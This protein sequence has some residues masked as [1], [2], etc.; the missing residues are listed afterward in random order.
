MTK[1]TRK[2][3]K[4]QRHRRIRAKI[5]GT[6]ERPRL[7]V[8]HSNAHL[9][10]QLIDDEKGKTIAA[11]SDLKLKAKGK[12]ADLA[13]KLGK[14]IA[15]KAKEYKVT[16]VVFDRGGAKYHGNLKAFAEEVRAQGIAL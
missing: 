12:G 9:Y 15:E 8:F 16:Q 10:A 6:A 1:P 7:F 2:N 14:E 11:V 13:K 5:S 3:R 4:M